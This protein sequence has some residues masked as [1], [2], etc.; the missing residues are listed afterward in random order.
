MSSTSQAHEKCKKN[1]VTIS[2]NGDDE[3]RSLLSLCDCWNEPGNPSGIRCG[4]TRYVE[5]SSDTLAVEKVEG[6]VHSYEKHKPVT[7]NQG[8]ESDSFEVSN[9]VSDGENTNDN[10]DSD[11]VS[12]E[13]HNF[14]PHY[15]FINGETCAIDP[16]KICL[17]VFDTETSCLDVDESRIL[18]IAFSSLSENATYSGKFLRVF[19]QNHSLRI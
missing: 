16:D 15:E 5:I 12:I 4:F 14:V 2:R 19:F 7:T 1:I 10:D 17:V 18:E 8:E 6:G 3:F 11:D 13:D 9:V